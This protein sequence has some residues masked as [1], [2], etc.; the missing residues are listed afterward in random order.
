MVVVYL[1]SGRWK[2]VGAREEGEEKGEEQ[3]DGDG[4][5]SLLESGALGAARADSRPAFNF[6]CF[7]GNL[8][9]FS[10]KLPVP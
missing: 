8:I 9:L 4:G 1:L 10:G 3:E 5:G 7:P 6:P 2:S